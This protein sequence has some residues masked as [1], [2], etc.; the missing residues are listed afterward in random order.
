MK[1]FSIRV[2]I[3]MWFTAAQ[4]LLVLFVGFIVL[5]A[6]HQAIQKTIRDNLVETVENNVD[7][8]EFF[9]S[10]DHAELY[11]ETDYFSI[12]RNGYLEIDDDFLQ[13]VN[14]VYTA[15]YDANAE[16]IY[17]ENPVSR[18]SG[19]LDFID[20]KLR[21]IRVKNVLFYVYDRKL[22]AKGLDGLWLRGVVSEDQGT[23]H[24]TDV[25]RLSLMFLPLLTLVSVVGGYLLTKR[26]LAPIQEI[27]E[28]ASKI[29]MGSDLKKRI[30]IGSGNDE[31]HQLADSFNGMFERLEKSFETERKF[32]ADAS[33]ELRTPVSVITAQCEFSLEQPRSAEEYE[34]ALQTIWR[35]G[36]KMSKLIKD[37]L[38]FTRL[39]MRA[40]SY[41]TE[42]VNMTELVES[43]CF[44]MAFIREKNIVLNCKAEPGLVLHGNR[45]LLSRLL[46][47]LINNAYRY[48]KEDGHIQVELKCGSDAKVELSVSDDGI[49]IAKEELPNIFLRF[50]Q[51]DN[52][53]SGGGAGL[54]LSM[55]QEIVKFH[56]GTIS[57]ESEPGQ[58]SV[59]LIKF[60]F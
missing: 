30:E 54:G 8:V 44:D 3:T 57:V 13:E 41:V 28:A 9:T 15:L 12:Y 26:M 16:L 49:G 6:H 37:M 58:G 39:E 7:E 31:V 21:S 55:V 20:A 32:T 18:E 24:T 14:E 23:Q 25:L 35:Q 11:N 36:R 53:R 60:L 5:F 46:I 40:E 4:L 22:T 50:Y 59:F 1:K 19:A 52:S 43:V 33:H 17:G 45:Q 48:G 2:K 47:N 34:H 42:A 29:G 10:L 51:A 27:S 38:D 56:G